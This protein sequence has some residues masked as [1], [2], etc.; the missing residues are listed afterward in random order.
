MREADHPMTC[1]GPSGVDEC[2]TLSQARRRNLL[3]RRL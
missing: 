2:D 3:F 1:T